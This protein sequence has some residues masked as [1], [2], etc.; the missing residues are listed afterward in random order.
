[1]RRLLDL[2]E[3][4]IA[5]LL[6]AGVEEAMRSIDL[7]VEAYRGNAA[8]SKIGELARGLHALHDE[9]A[10][11]AVEAI[12]RYSP[13]A[14]DLRF[15]R[16]AMEASYDLY[17]I[18][19]YSYDVAATVEGLGLICDDSKVAETAAKVKAL[20]RRAADML[21]RKSG[22][23]VEEVEKADDEVDEAYR[24]ALRAGVA[25]PTPCSLVEALALRFLERASDHAVYIARRA[26]Y[27]ATGRVE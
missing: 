23:G 9:V 2:A 20:L 27:L 8:A 26:R 5:E 16:V 12:A 19:R 13:V 21:L 11:L 10:E 14:A 1:M 6:A 4:R 17:R 18:A 22:E 15:L 3:R 25:S 24:G 7:A